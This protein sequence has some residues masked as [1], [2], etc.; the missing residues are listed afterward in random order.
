MPNVLAVPLDAAG[1]NIL[2]TQAKMIDNAEDWLKFSDMIDDIGVEQSRWRELMTV[3]SVMD[4]AARVGYPVL[5]RPSYVL[6]GAA[7]NVA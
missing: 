1:V 6:S 7:M 5:V 3:D 2:G 4:F